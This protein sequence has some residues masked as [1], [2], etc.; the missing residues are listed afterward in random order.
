[1]AERISE[2][3]MVRRLVLDHV[4]K[5]LPD[6]DAKSEPFWAIFAIQ[7]DGRPTGD[8]WAYEPGVV[9]V[10]DDRG[11]AEK[12]VAMLAKPNTPA[13]IFS[14]APVRWEARGLSRE[15][16][17]VLRESPG[18][19]LLVSCV[20]GAEGSKLAALPI[21]SFDELRAEVMAS[22]NPGPDEKPDPFWLIV[23][24]TDTNQ[25]IGEY[26]VYDDHH[27][28]VFDRKED[29]E[30]QIKLL[31]QPQTTRAS[32][33]AVRGASRKML[34]RIAT[35]GITKLQACSRLRNDG[36]LEV[37][38]LKVEAGNPTASP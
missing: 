33:W 34:H 18:V 14:T 17:Q 37:R 2:M 24:V 30:G 15:Y 10:F 38:D 32:S 31:P 29:A 13:G 21:D 1:M 36:Q 12:I 8:L 9:L 6:P 28:I 11:Q 4:N 27:V 25:T 7:E 23:P 22:M 3:E 5:F 19:R 35:N 26:W 16:L 20:N